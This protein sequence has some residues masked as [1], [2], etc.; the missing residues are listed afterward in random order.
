MTNYTIKVAH[1]ELVAPLLPVENIV[2][3]VCT[4][5][6]SDTPYFLPS[7]TPFISHRERSCSKHNA[8]EDILIVGG[9]VPDAP[10]FMQTNS[11][12]NY[13][14]VDTFGMQNLKIN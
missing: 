14:K 5:V 10:H 6:H 12:I 7:R 2:V 3:S 8:H 9:D 4:I 1:A 11:P 13:L